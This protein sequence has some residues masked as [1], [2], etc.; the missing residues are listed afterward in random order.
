[1]EYS[2]AQVKGTIS[3]KIQYG[4]KRIQ[5]FIDSGVPKKYC[6]IGSKKNKRAIW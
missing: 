3:Q 4:S 6:R 1:M 2:T 5:G